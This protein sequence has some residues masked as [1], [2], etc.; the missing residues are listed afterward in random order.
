MSGPP[1]IIYLQAAS[2]ATV[3]APVVFDLVTLVV[4]S[5]K[6]NR[7]LSEQSAPATS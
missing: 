5:I 6:P 4:N 2:S 7:T 1:I 3:A